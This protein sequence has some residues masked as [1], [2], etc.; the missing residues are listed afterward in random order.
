MKRRTLLRGL[1]AAGALAATGCLSEGSDGP[2]AD[3]DDPTDADT[4]DPTDADAGAPS[5]GAGD[6]DQPSDTPTDWAGDTITEPG[7]ETTGTPGDAPTDA[8]S[9]TPGGS[10]S[11]TPGGAVDSSLTVTGSECGVT[12]DEASVSFERDDVAVTVTGTIWGSD[13]CFTAV[14]SD[15]SLHEG[16]LTVA[17]AAESDAGTDTACAQCITEIDYE[18]AVDIDGALPR[19]VIVVHAHDGERR[20]VRTVER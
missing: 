16:T 15:V 13:A 8:A 12:V 19:K 6:T 9:E 5:D 1:S 17:V 3:T 7:G 14:L 2:A 18:T 10:P 20:T 4:D 11:G